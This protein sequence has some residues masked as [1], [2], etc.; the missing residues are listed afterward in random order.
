[1]PVRNHYG[2]HSPF[3]QWRLLLVLNAS[4]SQWLHWVHKVQ[5]RA[6]YCCLGC[7]SVGRHLFILYFFKCR[8]FHTKMM[9]KIL[10]SCN[11]KHLKKKKACT[12]LTL[13]FCAHA[14]I[15]WLHDWI[16][17][18][19]QDPFIL[20]CVVWIVNEIQ[21]CDSFIMGIGQRVVNKAGVTHWTAMIRINIEQLPY[22]LD[23]G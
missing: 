5:E 3:W 19:L 13:L 2:K 21:A 4:G 20:H 7:T 9:W 15:F 10:Q 17:F 16:L 23:T 11:M 18:C 6:F 1:M 14:F 22:S 12:I 8:K